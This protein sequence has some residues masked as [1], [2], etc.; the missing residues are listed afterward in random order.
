MNRVRSLLSMRGMLLLRDRLRPSVYRKTDARTRTKPVWRE[1]TR[2]SSPEIWAA[3][4]SKVWRDSG[5]ASFSPPHSRRR[6]EALLAGSEKRCLRKTLQNKILLSM[7]GVLLGYSLGLIAEHLIQRARLWPSVYQIAGTRTRINLFRKR[8]I[9]PKVW[10]AVTSKV[11]RDS[12]RASF[13]LPHSKR[14]QEEALLAGWS[15]LC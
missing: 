6:R 15:Y 11:W 8:L 4:S 3:A 2:L 12:G 9:S 14:Q 5:R 7:R 10:T 13:S 1:R